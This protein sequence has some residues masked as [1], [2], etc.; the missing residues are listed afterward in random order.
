M[1]KIYT[2]R[3]SHVAVLYWR[4]HLVLASRG[5]GGITGLGAGGTLLSLGLLGE[6]DSVTNIRAHGVLVPLLTGVN[7][8]GIRGVSSEGFEGVEVGGGTGL[9]RVPCGVN[10][11]LGVIV[12]KLLVVLSVLEVYGSRET[13][14]LL[15]GEGVGASG[16]EEYSNSLELSNKKIYYVRKNWSWT[17]NSNDSGR[18]AFSL[19]SSWHNKPTR[20]DVQQLYAAITLLI[21]SSDDIFLIVIPK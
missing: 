5:S 9:A 3:C 7:S 11:L 20:P 17:P 1:L 15:G 8:R 6:H 13:S 12:P 14:S 10:I 19:P 16:G 2:Q 18:G 21:T 4:R